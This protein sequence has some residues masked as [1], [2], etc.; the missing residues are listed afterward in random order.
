ML[1]NYCGRAGEFIY[2]KQYFSLK[3]VNKIPNEYFNSKIILIGYYNDDTNLWP[4]SLGYMNGLEINA[5]ILNTIIQQN[6]L[7]LKRIKN[8]F[9]FTKREKQ[10]NKFSGDKKAILSLIKKM[11]DE[12]N[13]K[14][15]NGLKK[16]HQ[17]YSNKSIIN[18]LYKEIV[19]GIK[20][21]FLLIKTIGIKIINNEAECKLLLLIKS[22]DKK[23]NNN[24][25]KQFNNI[26]FFPIYGKIK[27][28]KINN[29][30]Y[31]FE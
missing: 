28:K 20:S 18:N 7:T 17:K 2:Q 12:I 14:N 24:I 22:K 26:D 16:I 9:D 29:K 15:L 6:F 8:F 4:T 13:N 11:Q 25:K 1:I 23:I 21:D 27:F 19:Y 10:Q 30:W 3:D 5:N 31:I